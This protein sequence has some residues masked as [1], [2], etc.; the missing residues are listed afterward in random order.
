MDFSFSDHDR[1]FAEEARAWLEANVPPAWRRDHLW[2]RAEDPRWLEIA[3]PWQARLFA[4]GW[5][6]IA[7]P[8]EHG[9]RGA[10]VIER[11]LFDAELDRVGAPRPP[12]ASYVD[13][14]GPAI[15]HHGT[16][17]QRERFLRRML[18]GEE[19]WC[20]GFSEPGAGS[21]LGSL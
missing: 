18:S 11:W 16:A 13:L 3:R 2:T 17:P 8:R 5:A 12:T 9:G 21:D 1:A 6:A 20:Q 7:W 19:L 4:G 15:L 10:S 14:I